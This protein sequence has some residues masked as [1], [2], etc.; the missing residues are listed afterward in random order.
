MARKYPLVYTP[1]GDNRIDE[2]GGFIYQWANEAYEDGKAGASGFP[3]D[4]DREM[5]EF[6]SFLG[7]NPQPGTLRLLRAGIQVV[8]TAYEDGCK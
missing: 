2:F 4:F 7:H 6:R 3:I 5:K 8:N 1:T